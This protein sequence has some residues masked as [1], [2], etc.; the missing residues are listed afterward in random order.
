[1]QDTR[2]SSTETTKMICNEER[3][4]PVAASELAQTGRSALKMVAVQSSILHRLIRLGSLSDRAQDMGLYIASMRAQS[5][6]RS[7]NAPSN[8]T[9][10]LRLGQSTPTL[11]S[12]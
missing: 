10:G 1:M 12:C 4:T 3:K 11:S 8:I 6:L 2:N 7:S 5:F 9:A